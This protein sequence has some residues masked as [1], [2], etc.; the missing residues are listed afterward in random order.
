MSHLHKRQ[1]RALFWQHK[2]AVLA[3]CLVFTT[4][5]CC[6]AFLGPTLWDLGCQTGTSMRE[7]NL[8]FLVQSFFMFLGTFLGG[9]L[10]SKYAY[11]IATD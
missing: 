8:V 10:M 9:V 1:F 7:M 11:P 3:F 5:G 2:L 4:F 6:V